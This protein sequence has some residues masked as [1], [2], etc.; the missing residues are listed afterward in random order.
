MK[1]GD[2]M[3]SVWKT[4]IQLSQYEPLRQD[5]KTDVLIIGGGITGILCAD[6]LR[7]AGVSHVLAEARS[8]CGGITG[9]TTA[10]I[11]VQHGLIFSKLLREFGTERTQMYLRANRDALERYRTMSRTIDCDFEEQLSAVYTLDDPVKIENELQALQ[12]ISA[13]AEYASSLPLPFPIRGAVS[14][15][16]QA[17]F[18]P[19]KFLS[20][21]AQEL[22]VCENTRILELTPNGA[23]TKHGTIKADKIIVATH[24]PFLNKHGSYFL[25]LY[26][27]RSYV[28]ALNHAPNIQGMYVDES[29][30]GLSFRSYGDHLLVGGGGHRT[31]KKGGGWKEPEQ[32]A[33]RY[34]PQSSLSSR[35]AAQDCM[36]LDGIPYAGQYSKRTP[37]LYVATGFNKWGMT[38]AMVAASLLTDLVLGKQNPYTELFSPSRTILRPQLMVNAAESAL[39]LLKPTIPRC[40][41][42]GCALTY[43]S[44][45]HSW[46]CPCHG[47]RFT[48]DGRLLDNPATGDM[49]P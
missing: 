45:E 24:F 47:S 7:E 9:N 10:K 6:R 31:G 26:Q 30:A 25:K 17:Q 29:D 16:G 1:K 40:P 2:T 35:W 34:Y 4:D 8:L 18:H 3:D 20:A 46:D 49:K 36:T 43:N 39:H 23:V 41:H 33:Q 21:I 19:L 48:E 13:P 32:F 42:M 15:A 27:S 11:T 28:L 12:K 37:N 5:I 14:F 22:S 44:Q 38:S